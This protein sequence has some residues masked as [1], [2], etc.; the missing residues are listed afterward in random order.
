M[1]AATTVAVFGLQ[2][3]FIC[4]VP[5]AQ[6]TSADGVGEQS[7]KTKIILREMTEVPL[8]FAEDVNSRSARQGQAVEFVLAE[9][10]KVGAVIVAKRGS[11]ALGTVV[12]S[13][14]PD[15][16]GNPGEV[17]VRITF[18]KAGN[19]KVPL[20]GASD[21]VGRRYVIVRGSQAVLKAGT[22]VMAYV[23]ADT[24]VQALDSPPARN[25]P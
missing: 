6:Q 17:N 2:C 16:W 9:D 18:L 23:D 10:L 7:P 8:K 12:H 22:P 20:R 4:G 5:A 1:R 14:T 13:K 25:A 19:T 15:F 3:L 11:R 24:E 21:G